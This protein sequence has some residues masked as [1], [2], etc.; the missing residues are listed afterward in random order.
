[1]V[2]HSWIHQPRLPMASGPQ[3]AQGSLGQGQTPCRS[4][5]L[6]V[7]LL[8]LGRHLQDVVVPPWLSHGRDLVGFPK[9][10]V[11]VLGTNG[12]NVMDVQPSN[13]EFQPESEEGSL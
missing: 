4:R 6:D 12:G 11:V 9:I 5:F 3:L 8:S 10:W 13:P 2:T 1:M 7:F